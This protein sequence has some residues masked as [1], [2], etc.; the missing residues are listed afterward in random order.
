LIERNIRIVEEAH[1]LISEVLAHRRARLLQPPAP[2]A[3]LSEVSDQGKSAAREGEIKLAWREAD[4]FPGYWRLVAKV[5]LKEETFDQL[6]NGRSG[7]RAQYYLSPEEGVLFNYDVL[8]ALAPA[9]EQA[10]LGAS[11]NVDWQLV[12]R[13]LAGPH[14]KVWVFEEKKAFDEAVSDALNPPRWVGNGATRGRKAPLPDHRS[15]DVKGTFIDPDSLQ[16]RVDD[17]KLDRAC[18]IFNKG[19]T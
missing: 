14:A 5:P 15:I 9:L 17:Y 4:D 1:W 3:L 6:L 12:R 10:F 8:S 18:D 16:F 11:L 2:I 19:Y 13:S 7:Y